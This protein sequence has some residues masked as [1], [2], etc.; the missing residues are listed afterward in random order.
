MFS[1]QAASK[2]VNRNNNKKTFRSQH[3]LIVFPYLAKIKHFHSKLTSNF[4]LS[5]LQNAACHFLSVPLFHVIHDNTKLSANV[6]LP[7]SSRST[8]WC[9]SPFKL[10]L[11]P[12]SLLLSCYSSIFS[13]CHVAMLWLFLMS[14]S[15]SL[16]LPSDVV[17]LNDM[18]YNLIK[19]VFKTLDKLVNQFLYESAV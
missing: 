15:L 3:Y 16:I 6:N 4:Y 7:L 17:V 18:I 5:G 10:N 2:R 1:F 12:V 9:P 13:C 14:L 8:G 11:N 19:W